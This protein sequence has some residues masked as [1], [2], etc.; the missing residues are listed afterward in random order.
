MSWVLLR[1]EFDR[2]WPERWFKDRDDAERW[3]V[4]NPPGENDPL[5]LVELLDDGTTGDPDWFTHVPEPYRGPL[6]R[7]RVDMASDPT[8][9]HRVPIDCLRPNGAAALTEDTR[10]RVVA[11]G[12]EGDRQGFA[13][14]CGPWQEIEGSPEAVAELV[15]R[16][17]IR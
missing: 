17:P 13:C 4:E 5:A 6:V 10:W 15:E 9:F 12:Y 7:A 2:L 14:I 11:T 3:I 16:Y 8:C 1:D